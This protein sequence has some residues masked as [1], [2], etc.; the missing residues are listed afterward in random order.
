[1]KTLKNILGYIISILLG[2]IITPMFSYATMSMAGMSKRGPAYYVPEEDVI[3]ERIMGTIAL[4]LTINVIIGVELLLW[5]KF[6][7]HK[8]KLFIVNILIVIIVHLIFYPL[9]AWKR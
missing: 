5:L 3:F 6:F 2:F 1:M 7:K 8:K 4:G 9:F